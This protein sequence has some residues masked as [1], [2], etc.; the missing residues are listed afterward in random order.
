[1]NTITRATMSNK[2][3]KI[4][5]IGVIC[6]SLASTSL[7]MQRDT[8]LL[9]DMKED[10]PEPAPPARDPAFDLAFDKH[11][12]Y[13]PKYLDKS[14]RGENMFNGVNHE[15]S[16]LKKLH[17][18]IVVLKCP[19]VSSY[20]PTLTWLEHEMEKCGFFTPHQ[21]AYFCGREDHFD[22]M[23]EWLRRIRR[24]KNLADRTFNMWFIEKHPLERSFNERKHAREAAIRAGPTPEERAANKEFEQG[25]FR[26]QD[27]QRAD[28][29]GLIRYWEH[30]LAAAKAAKGGPAGGPTKL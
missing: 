6:A 18:Q 24:C 10:Y 7:G 2:S 15:L 3:V 4:C 27:L 26:F 22:Y 19:N 21:T 20:L 1:M 25:L 11:I 13:H 30:L 29:D 8:E 14:M 23:K 12:A 9:H 17:E 28:E 16:Q 5:C